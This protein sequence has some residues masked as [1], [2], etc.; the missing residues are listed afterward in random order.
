MMFVDPENLGVQAAQFKEAVSEA[1]L[2]H[3]GKILWV[4]VSY[5]PYNSA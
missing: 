1:I 3:S 2:Y 5:M 4:S